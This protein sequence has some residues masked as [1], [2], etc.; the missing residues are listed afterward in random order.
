MSTIYGKGIYIMGEPPAP[1]ACLTFSSPNRFTLKVNDNTKHW[2]GTLEYSTNASTWSTWDGTTKLS[3][4]RK[5]SSNV[6]YLRGIGNT[7]ITGN[8][9]YYNE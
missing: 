1:T 2:D 7:V 6:L 8:S 4:A 9:P 5:G 3:S